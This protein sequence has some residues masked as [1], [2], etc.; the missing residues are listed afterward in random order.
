MTLEERNK[1]RHAREHGRRA[2]WIAE[3]GPCAECG[4]SEDLEV[5]HVDPTTKDPAL[6]GRRAHAIWGWR[7]GRRIPELAKCQALCHACHAA[8]SAE[9]LRTPDHGTRG[10]YRGGCRCAECNAWNTDRCRRKRIRRK[11]RTALV[12]A[13]SSV[14]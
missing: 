7:E 11:E 2:Q 10:R 12:P 8:K 9:E 1:R 13:D 14:S 6:R 3:H 5:D 4:A